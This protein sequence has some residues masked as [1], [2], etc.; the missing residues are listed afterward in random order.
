MFVKVVSCLSKRIYKE[1][2]FSFSTVYKTWHATCLVQLVY[3]SP[4][5]TLTPNGYLNYSDVMIKVRSKR[6][7]ESESFFLPQDHRRR[8]SFSAGGHLGL[9]TQVRKTHPLSKTFDNEKERQLIA[10][11]NLLRRE[12]GLTEN[13]ILLLSIMHY[14]QNKTKTL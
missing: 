14:K 4:L 8:S 5:L 2:S 3:C 13:S 6:H 11:P 7:R 12:C 1:G 9:W 10:I